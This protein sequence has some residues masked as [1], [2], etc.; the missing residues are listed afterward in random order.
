MRHHFE[1]SKLKG[2]EEF[3]AAKRPKTSVAQDILALLAAAGMHIETDIDNDV[4]REIV[5]YFTYAGKR[6][7]VRC[8]VA[9]TADND[10]ELYRQIVSEMLDLREVDKHV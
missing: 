4:Y 3:M 7:W 5:G 8:A 2:D 9:R 10:F 6:R 1:V